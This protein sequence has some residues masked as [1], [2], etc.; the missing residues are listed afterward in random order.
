MIRN[1]RADKP[2]KGKPKTAQPIDPQKLTDRKKAEQSER[3]TQ[4]RLRLA[5]RSANIGLW[6]WNIKTNTVNFS[7]EWKQ[8]LGYE[9]HEIS[10]EFSEWEKRV[11][12]DDL[13]KT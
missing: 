4:E 8:Q 6:D 9:D 10:D 3:E 11:H 5:I 7:H 13:E 12:P 2:L 1:S